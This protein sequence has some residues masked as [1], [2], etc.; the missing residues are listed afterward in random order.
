MLFNIQKK[1]Y[2]D[3]YIKKKLVLPTV[4]KIAVIDLDGTLLSTSNKIPELSIVALRLLKKHK[5]EPIICT[6]RHSLIVIKKFGQILH[7]N[8]VRYY[9]FN[10]GA[11]IYDYKLKKN[12][13]IYY[14]DYDDLAELYNYCFMKRIQIISY[15]NYGV[16]ANRNVAVSRTIFTYYRNY[17]H[18]YI[19]IHHYR[20]L[21]IYRFYIPFSINIF[22]NL[23][24][25]VEIFKKYR[26][27][28]NITS[29][30]HGYSF[31]AKP[32]TK[33]S[34][35]QKICEILHCDL[36]NTVAFGDGPNDVSMAKVANFSIAMPISDP[37]LT[38]TANIQISGNRE[39]RFYNAVKYFL[40]WLKNKP[41]QFKVQ[42][43]EN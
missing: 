1:H 14:L 27:L 42:K 24:P 15:T 21:H 30:F 23:Q 36:R 17:I 4:Q 12:I 41:K 13:C 28:F 33:G 11:I 38:R 6:Q 20:K 3:L 22:H 5:I 10:N 37:E 8:G 2:R 40:G 32:I 43:N 19:D 25:P 34:G 26:K 16:F 29:M 18:S 35:L 31:N 9:I 39:T 7:K